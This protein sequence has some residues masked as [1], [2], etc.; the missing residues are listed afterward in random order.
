M[1]KKTQKTKQRILMMVRKKAKNTGGPS[2]GWHE[3]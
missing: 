3:A 1:T 2:I